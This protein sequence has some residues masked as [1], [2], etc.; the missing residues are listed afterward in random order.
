MS[1]IVIEPGNRKVALQMIA[2]LVLRRTRSIG[3]LV[4]RWR[5]EFVDRI[6]RR[7]AGTAVLWGSFRCGSATLMTETGG[8]RLI[9]GEA[10]F[11]GSEEH[12]RWF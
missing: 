2:R 10:A 9:A 11:A 12:T 5:E 7:C 3:L 1:W 6:G 8:F 4:E